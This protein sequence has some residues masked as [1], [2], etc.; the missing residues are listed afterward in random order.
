MKKIFFIVFILT[1]AGLYAQTATISPQVINSAGGYKYVG[2]LGVTVTDNVGEPF[3]ETLGNSKAIITQGFI[4]PEVAS[5]AGFIPIIKVNNVTCL[6]KNNG[7]IS[8]SLV[9]APQAVNFTINYNWTPSGVCPGQNC[10]LLDSLPA[11]TY[12]VQMIISYT[13]INGSA[14][15]DTITRTIPVT[16]VP[17]LCIIHIYSGIT[18]NGD[19]N[20]D[21]FTIDNID[22][23]PN[24][25]V[26]LYNRWGREM[27]SIK[28]YDNG[29]KSWPNNN[30]LAN[31]T[32]STYFYVIDLGNGGPLIK[33]WVELIKD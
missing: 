15:T 6:D 5:Y 30:K 2:S 4:Q 19:N 26:T 28:G 20:N 10:Y 24:N 8:I 25:T 17:E 31:M 33:G 7:D 12:T 21:V 16:S 11:Q 32:A 9:R 29:G 23:F 22:M 13:V 3:T 18:P 27:A 1:V 14:K